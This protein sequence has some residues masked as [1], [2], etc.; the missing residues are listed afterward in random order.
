MDAIVYRHTTM[1]MHGNE[2]TRPLSRFRHRQ[3]HSADRSYQPVNLDRIRTDKE[4]AGARGGGSPLTSARRSSIGSRPGSANAP[5]KDS[6]STRQ[7]R[8]RWECDVSEDCIH[9]LLGRF[10]KSSRLME[11]FFFSETLPLLPWVC[12][13]TVEHSSRP[14]PL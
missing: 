2:Y 9:Y 1:A 6:N 5:P 11:C 13:N 7:V 12:G 8:G 4:G 3:C 14:L 10:V